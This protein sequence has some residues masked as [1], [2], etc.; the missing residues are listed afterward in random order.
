MNQNGIFII[1][2]DATGTGSYINKG[3]INY[4]G[5]AI[6]TVQRYITGHNWHYVSSPI[7]NA[8]TT[9]F[10]PNNFYHYNETTPDYWSMNTFTGGL[11]GWEFASGA[12]TVMRGY[13]AYQEYSTVEFTGT[14][15]TGN[16]NYNLDYTDNTGTHGNAVYDGWNL[17]GNPYPSA[18]N[19]NSDDITRTNVDAA[20]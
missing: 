11:M 14:L 4:G 16:L 1:Q 2:S 9:L 7:T 3:T 18:L 15:N 8:Q 10:H 5:S 6:T 13:A 19:W 12:M 17:V 20:M